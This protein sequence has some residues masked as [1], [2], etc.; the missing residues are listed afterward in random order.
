MES[1][2]K[3]GKTRENESQEI[4]ET[5]KSPHKMLST[6]WSK[7]NARVQNEV[8]YTEVGLKLSFSLSKR[9][10]S[11]LTKLLQYTISW[12]DTSRGLQYLI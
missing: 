7:A 11:S 9:L 2:R 1:E 4:P 8:P 6:T 3:L 5:Q 10:I 12:L